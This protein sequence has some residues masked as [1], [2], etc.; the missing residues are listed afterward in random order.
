MISII[1]RTTMMIT[2]IMSTTMTMRMITGKIR[3]M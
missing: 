3:M 1:M 2:T